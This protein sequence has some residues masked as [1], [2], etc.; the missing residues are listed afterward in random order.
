MRLIIRLC[1]EAINIDINTTITIILRKS[2]KVTRGPIVFLCLAALSPGT[3]FVTAQRNRLKFF[4]AM[5]RVPNLSEIKDILREKK[6]KN[7][8]TKWFST[9][10]FNA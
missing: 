10:N 8:G 3:S 2:P 9:T 1:W 7:I 6:T 5:N 4:Y